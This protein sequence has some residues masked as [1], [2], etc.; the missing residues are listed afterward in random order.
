MSTAYIQNY[1]DFW[2]F[3]KIFL[4]SFNGSLFLFDCKFS[5]DTEDFEN[6]YQVFIMP[7]LSENEINGSWYGLS[8]KSVKYLGEVP[9]NQVQFDETRKKFING[10]IITGLTKHLM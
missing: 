9:I 2:D 4:V 10:E 1:R 8:D 6:K 7:E 3:P 5:N